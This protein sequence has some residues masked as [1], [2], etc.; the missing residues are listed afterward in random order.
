MKKKHSVHVTEDLLAE[1]VIDEFAQMH[2]G[3]LPSFA[4]RGMAAVRRNSKKILDKFHSD[5]DGVFLLHRALLLAKEDAFEQLPELLAEEVLAVM[6][7]DQIGSVVASELA[8]E[9]ATGLPLQAV[10]WGGP[11]RAPGELAQMYLGG[12]EASIPPEIKVKSKKA[13]SDIHSALGCANSHT[14]K[15]LAALFNLRTRYLTKPPT[16]GFG[17]IV[18]WRDKKDNV[19][20]V[21]YGFCLMP[22]CDS[23]RL[24]HGKGS[25]T[26]FPFWTLKEGGSG[27]SGLGIVVPTLENSYTQLLVNGKP[28]D[29]LWLA[30]FKPNQSFTVVA[31]VDGP[32]FVFKNKA[33]RLEWVA[34]L[35]PIHAQRIAN[36]IGQ[37][38]SRVGVVEAEWLRLSADGKL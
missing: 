7:D 23:I 17:T 5:M 38:F 12:G 4:L 28:R 18:R 31:T 1:R 34:Q 33:K 16:L 26:S 21:Y 35:K 8:K 37:S 9:V 22:L 24:D 30:K 15:K 25:E 11:G 29:M 3:I 6:L 27:G 20:S 36:H 13:I 32:N 10:T 2:S 19:E 14:D